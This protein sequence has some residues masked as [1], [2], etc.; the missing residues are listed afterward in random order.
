[1]ILGP[2]ALPAEALEQPYVQLL[3]RYY[4]VDGDSGAR[5]Q[6]RL[7]DIVVAGQIEVLENLS[8]FAQWWLNAGCEAGN[9]YCDGADLNRDGRVDLVDFAALARQWIAA[10]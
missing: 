3:W 9:Q 8:V 1:E 6:L 2:I 10:P 5:A 7:D 4:H